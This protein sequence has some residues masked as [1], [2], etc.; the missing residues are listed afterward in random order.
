MTLFLWPK[1]L[2]AIEFAP[3]EIASVLQITS[4]LP[5]EA[6]DLEIIS[7]AGWFTDDELTDY[8]HQLEDQL[9]IGSGLMVTYSGCALTNKHVVYSETAETAHQDIHLWSTDNLHQAPQDLGPA[10]VVMSANF[11]DLALVCLENPQGKFY[12][13][14]SLNSA[15]YQNFKLTLGE[16]I[17]NLGYPASG[18]QESLTLTA[19]LVAGVWDD[20]YLKGDLTV[21]GGASGS[22]VFNKNKQVV[23]L[24]TGNA[25]ERG[26]YGIF[27]KPSYVYGWRDLYAEI[28]REVITESAGCFDAEQFGVYKKDGQEFYDLS[29]SIK[30][31]FGLEDKIAFEYQQYCG[32]DLDVDD[33]IKVAGYISSNKTT[34]NHWVGYLEQSCLADAS[35]ITVF[36]APAE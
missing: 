3:K 13:H 26:L 33:L 25:G 23:S 6:I 21:T 22:P 15:D 16:E 10:T 28:Y 7:L 27:L 1:L 17:F 9:Q 30:R 29:C 12:P 19:G 24:I 32:A 14:F 8:R 11:V 5:K 35:P 31:N 20:D 36:E 4:S 34:I 2:W 18:E